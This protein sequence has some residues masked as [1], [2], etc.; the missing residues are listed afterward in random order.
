[1]AAHIAVHGLTE[2]PLVGRHNYHLGVN[3]LYATCLVAICIPTV[4]RWLGHSEKYT[5]E[6]WP[7]RNRGLDTV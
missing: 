4:C 7:R 5:P 3:L 2:V 1:M 6:D